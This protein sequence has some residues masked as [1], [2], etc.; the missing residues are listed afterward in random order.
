MDGSGDGALWDRILEHRAK[1]AEEERRRKE[2]LLG[3]GRRARGMI[4]YGQAELF[5]HDSDTDFAAKDDQ[6]RVATS[7]SRTVGVSRHLGLTDVQ[8]EYWDPFLVRGVCFVEP[9]LR[10]R[11]CATNRDSQA[12]A[13]RYQ[14]VAW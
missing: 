13:H 4:N 1:E 3:R 10:M 7:L 14:D 6:I 8:A 9:H 12:P 11:I 5:D 2:A